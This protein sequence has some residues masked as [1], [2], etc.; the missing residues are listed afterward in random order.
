MPAQRNRGSVYQLY[1]LKYHHQLMKDMSLMPPKN[2]VFSL[3]T[4]ITSADYKAAFTPP[5]SFLEEDLSEAAEVEASSTSQ[6][7]FSYIRVGP[8]G[9]ACKAL[10][11]SIQLD[12]I[13]AI[14]QAPKAAATAAA[15]ALVEYGVERTP[16]GSACA[17][18]DERGLFG[19]G[20]QCRPSPMGSAMHSPR[21]QGVEVLGKLHAGDSSANRVA[22]AAVAVSARRAVTF[23]YGQLRAARPVG[24][25]RLHQATAKP[26]AGVQLQ[27]VEG[28]AVTPDSEFIV[29]R[30]AAS[31]AGSFT[32]RHAPL[33]T[34]TPFSFDTGVSTSLSGSC[35]AAAVARRREAE[36]LAAA[37]TGA[38]NTEAAGTSSLSA[39]PWLASDISFELAGQR[40]LSGGT[41]GFGSSSSRDAFGEGRGDSSSSAPGESYSNSTK[42]LQGATP[43]ATGKESRSMVSRE[44]SIVSRG[45]S[46]ASKAAGGGSWPHR[47]PAVPHAAE[48]CPSQ[49]P[50][51][52]IRQ[53]VVQLQEQAERERDMATLNQGALSVGTVWK[54]EE[55]ERAEVTS[56]SE[57]NLQQQ[58]LSV[59]KEATW[60]MSVNSN[61]LA[62][63]PRGNA[64]SYQ[65][66]QQQQ[67]VNTGYRSSM[68][69]A[70]QQSTSRSSWEYSRHASSSRSSSELSR[71]RCNALQ[72]LDPAALAGAAEQAMRRHKQLSQ[73]QINA[74]T[75]TTS[76]STR[77]P[78]GGG[79]GSV[80][81]WVQEGGEGNA[82][83]GMFSSG[84]R[85]PFVKGL[86]VEGW[87]VPGSI[88][89]RRMSLAFEPHMAAPLLSAENLP[90]A[91]TS[92]AASSN[93][94]VPAGP[95]QQQQQQQ[96]HL[97]SC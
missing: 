32:A 39:G 65:Q 2:G 57:S 78:A 74:E 73:R 23:N 18:I 7:Q 37:T 42:H 43:A 81:S 94:R 96:A 17:S 48:S 52:P 25:H 46:H 68:D 61:N 77:D 3:K 41:G 50:L 9:E 15:A 47:S 24:S 30:S 10:K 26:Q 53:L 86:R 36:P 40:S 58:G 90:L 95:Q 14:Q 11:S 13:A 79:D 72:Q 66:Q 16:S 20:M 87:E 59:P 27:H 85:G 92:L 33:A 56:T 69:L 64:E 8:G 28:P 83:G 88:Q 19:G 34:S 49:D 54:R 35:F 6:A 55:Q 71:Q 82:G 31:A 84:Y 44:A 63:L 38:S 76:T 21:P 75:S 4:I 97:R 91:A 80:A 45:S 67:K 12:N 29:E 60:L 1:M 62:P 5:P 93:P 51:G 89:A 70:R 22:A